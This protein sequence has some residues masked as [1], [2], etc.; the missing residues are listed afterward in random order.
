MSEGAERVNYLQLARA[1]LFNGQSV[2]LSLFGERPH[3]GKSDS[4]VQL[5]PELL[6][7]QNVRLSFAINAKDALDA[8]SQ[9]NTTTIPQENSLLVDVTD[10]IIDEESSFLFSQ[11]VRQAQL[12][13][14]KKPK[15]C[16]LLVTPSVLNVSEAVEQRA[17]PPSR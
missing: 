17:T 12:N 7:D 9:I 2:E 16:F 6:K 5:R 11:W 1:A 15:R 8:L 10:H 13:Q 3:Q 14:S 4:L